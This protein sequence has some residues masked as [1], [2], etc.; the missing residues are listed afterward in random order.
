V[1]TVVGILREVYGL[2]VE[3]V[4]F[5]IAILVWIALFAVVVHYLQGVARGMILFAGFA[6]VLIVEVGRASRPAGERRV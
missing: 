1:K 5:A 6:A 2:F 3:D 4:G